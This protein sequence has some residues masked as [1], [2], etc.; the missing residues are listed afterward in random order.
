MTVAAAGNARQLIGRDSPQTRRLL[1]GTR[2]MSE[3]LAQQLH[4]RGVDPQHLPRFSVLRLH[5][6]AGESLLAAELRQQDTNR[7]A[8]RDLPGQSIR[9]I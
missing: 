6:S 8:Q 3:K 5:E 4:A 9:Q 7:E 2:L 1:D